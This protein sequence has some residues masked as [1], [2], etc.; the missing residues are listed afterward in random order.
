[1]PCGMGEWL[2]DAGLLLSSQL[3]ATVATTIVAI[4]LARSL[5]PSDW[6]LLSGLL[7]L[8]LALSIFV[9]FGLGNLVVA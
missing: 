4:L 7:G 6:G 5:G 8:S 1:M 2:K 3:I 9:D